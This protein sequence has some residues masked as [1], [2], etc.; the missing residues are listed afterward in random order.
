M[1]IE[2]LNHVHFP[3]QQCA[4]EPTSSRMVFVEVA[5]TIWSFDP[6]AAR[7]VILSTSSPFDRERLDVRYECG[8]FSKLQ[9]AS[10][11]GSSSVAIRNRTV[12]VCA[13]M[14]SLRHSNERMNTHFSP[15][16]C[17]AYSDGAWH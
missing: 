7:P 11:K 17:L 5:L 3:L 9:Y 4:R 14:H 1:R 2:L 15:A 10:S 12:D 16:L 13:S 6:F 8:R